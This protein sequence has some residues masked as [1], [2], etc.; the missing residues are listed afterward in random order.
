[1]QNQNIDQSQMPYLNTQA[2]PMTNVNDGRTL[3]KS[4][5]K[6]LKNEQKNQ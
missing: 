6:A 4:E 2:L 5:K 3:S 1:M